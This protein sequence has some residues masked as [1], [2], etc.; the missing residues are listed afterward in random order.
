MIYILT[1]GI[2]AGLLYSLLA[3][4]VFVSF[5]ILNFA[6]LSAE[7]TITLGA[8][9]MAVL[10]HQETNLFLATILVL[11]SGFIA[12]AFTGILNTKLKIPPILAGIIVMTAL[13]SINLMILGAANLSIM[14]LFNVFTPLNTLIS[15]PF[16]ARS[17][18]LFVVV[19]LIAGILYFLFG[20]EIGMA[21]RATG[22]NKDMA[23]AQGINTDLMIIL[24]LAISNA[25]IALGG[26]LVA[27]SNG[28]ANL[29]MGRGTIVIGLAS[30]IIGE[31]VTGQKTFKVW[32]FSIIL[33]SILYQTLFSIII[34]F[35]INTNLLQLLQAILITIIL[36]IPI[37]KKFII[38]KETLAYD[39]IK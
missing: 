35:N 31:A 29:N 34:Y 20:T 6:D 33:G 8:V 27:Q 4:G 12:G 15:N 1:D 38:N 28:A 13:Y 22:M 11:I 7:G 24:G 19:L 14:R 9:I 3:L 18:T 30:I 39:K 26:S 25:I 21:I 36:G 23:K 37:I 5:R 17:I 10:I 32:L 16:L 2:E